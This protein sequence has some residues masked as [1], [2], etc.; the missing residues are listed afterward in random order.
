MRGT[1][2]PDPVIVIPMLYDLKDTPLDHWEH[3]HQFSAK[4]PVHK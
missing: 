2:T 4:S 3:F 1:N